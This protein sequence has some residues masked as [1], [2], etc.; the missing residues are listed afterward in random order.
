MIGFKKGAGLGQGAGAHL[1]ERISTSMAERLAALN[2]SRRGAS[3][4]IT[5]MRK[6]M[7]LIA[8]FILKTSSLKKR[9]CKPH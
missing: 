9:T 6:S 4:V 7:E 3:R 2:I 5:I 1:R 8:E